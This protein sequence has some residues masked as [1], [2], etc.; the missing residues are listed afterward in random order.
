DDSPAAALANGTIC[1]RHEGS[2]ASA[3]ANSNVMEDCAKCGTCGISGR[4]ETAREI[5]QPARAK[6]AGFRLAALAGPSLFDA[7]S[8]ARAGANDGVAGFAIINSHKVARHFTAYEADERFHLRVHLGHSVAHI[9]DDFDAREIH[10]ELARQIQDHFQALEIA[11][12]I[13]PRVALRARRL[14]QPH[15]LVEAQRLRVK[16]IELGYGADH[17]AR[18]GSF[19]GTRCHLRSPCRCPL[20]LDCRPRKDFA[21]GIFVVHFGQLLQQIPH[22]L[23]FGL[24]HH[25]LHF[26]DLVATFAG[27]ARRGS[28]FFAQAK[29][30]PAVCTRWDAHLRAPVDGGDLHFRAERSFRDR[31]RHNRIEIVAAALEKRMGLHFHDDVEIARRPAMHSGVS[32]SG[33]THARAGLRAG[34]N[35]HVERLDAR[36]APFAAAVPADGVQPPSA[37]A[38]RA[39]NLK[40]HLAAHLLSLAGPA[41][42]G[43][44]FFIAWHET[45]AVA[46]V[47]HIEAS[48][49][50]L[51]HGPAHGLCKSDVNLILEVVALLLL[52]RGLGCSSPP[53]E[54][55]EEIVKTGAASSRCGASA[56]IKTAEIEVNIF[57]R[58]ATS[59]T[60]RRAAA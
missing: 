1:S 15:A 53:E 7:D 47:A 59:R 11:V 58:A 29:L 4:E 24:G 14:Q 28:A 27:M 22:A 46:D 19:L 38:A 45:G 8:V 13:K 35:A 10:T 6:I 57:G 43:A 3:A 23:I 41:A 36:Q 16:M 40:A 5:L 20:R 42:C 52:L 31:Y 32:S 17:V 48:E 44:H 39:G 12:G 55:A 25:H 50:D 54:L 56:K 30:F 18:S 37:A 2:L 33:H 51:L 60:G 9:E 34:R 26:H 49:G 21:A